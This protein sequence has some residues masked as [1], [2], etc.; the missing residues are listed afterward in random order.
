LLK[1]ATPLEAC[2]VVVPVRAELL[3]ERLSEMLSVLVVMTF[4]KEFSTATCTP[5]GESIVVPVVVLEGWVMKT[6]EFESNRRHSSE[7]TTARIS[8]DVTRPF[9]R[10]TFLTLAENIGPPRLD[11]SEI[12]QILGDTLTLTDWN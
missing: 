5:M 2:V 6:S 10:R 1:V 7:S 4:P 12:A 9:D 11:D 8:G 3:G